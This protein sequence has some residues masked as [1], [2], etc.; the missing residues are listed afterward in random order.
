MDSFRNKKNN[1]LYEGCLDPRKRNGL[2]LGPFFIEL[3]N[4]YLAAL[5]TFFVLFLVVLLAFIGFLR[6]S[7]TTH[8]LSSYQADQPVAFLFS[9]SDI[10]Y[11]CLVLRL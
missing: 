10:T 4:A 6:L 5:L 1:P 9:S 2:T 7:S 11:C 3:F 8:L